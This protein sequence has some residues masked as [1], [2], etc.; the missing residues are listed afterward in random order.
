MFE[1]VRIIFS[2]LVSAA[3]VFK[4][5]FEMNNFLQ[6]E[7]TSNIEKLF[8]K[9]YDQIQLHAWRGCNITAEIGH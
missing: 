8:L 2:W 9:H 3:A 6:D 1:A 4:G 7:M 5:Y